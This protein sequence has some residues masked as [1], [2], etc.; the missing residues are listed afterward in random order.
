MI[1]EPAGLRRHEIECFPTLAVVQHAHGINLR[2][3]GVFGMRIRRHVVSA[4]ILIDEQHARADRDREFFRTHTA[5]GQRECVGIGRRRR[6]A[7]R[8]VAPATTRGEEKTE[9]Y[10]EDDHSRSL[11]MVIG[12]GNPRRQSLL[13]G[14]PAFQTGILR[15]I[16]IVVPARAGVCKPECRLR[17]SGL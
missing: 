5:G 1:V 13:D 16:V 6:R 8:R 15:I 9:N 11:P 7:R 10:N 12:E 17:L 3:V 2:A 4:R 14:D